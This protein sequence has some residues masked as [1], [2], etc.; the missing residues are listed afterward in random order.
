MTTATS[1]FVLPC[2]AVLALVAPGCSFFG[3][4][5]AAVP[6]PGGAALTQGMSTGLQS[7]VAKRQQC[8][9]DAAAA[10]AG[11]QPLDATIDPSTGAPMLTGAAPPSSGTQIA[12][13]ATGA[14]S[15]GMCERTDRRKAKREAKREAKR[16]AKAR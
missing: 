10:A 1:R 13:V 11:A 7:I 6:V 12:A 5:G 3:S 16:K 14:L 2:L 8:K 9:R 15:N 4:L